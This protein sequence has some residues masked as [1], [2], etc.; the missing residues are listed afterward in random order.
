MIKFFYKMINPKILLNT[1]ATMTL[2]LACDNIQENETSAIPVRK[3]SV[4]EAI[5][6]P[7]PKDES[8]AHTA[9]IP[10]E[11]A[12]TPKV[13]KTKTTEE[14]PRARKIRH[15]KK[16]I[17]PVTEETDNSEDLSTNYFK[18]LEFIKKQKYNEALRS[19]DKVIE[20]D[21]TF[22]DAYYNRA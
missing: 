20:L 11:N 5:S 22:Q 16:S 19:L 12:V 4:A 14:K 8:P 10:E 7:L 13:E 1:I 15:T 9:G 18:A 3:D 2:L 6:H 21:S 17:N